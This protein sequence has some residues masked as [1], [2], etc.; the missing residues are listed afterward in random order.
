VP[1]ATGYWQLLYHFS[2]HELAERLLKTIRKQDSIR[3]GDRVAAAVSAGADSVALLCLLLELRSELGIVLSVA[4]VNHKLR[5]EESDEDERFVSKLARQHELELDVRDAPV[6]GRHI[7]E[8]R[9]GIEAAARELRHGFFRQLAREGRAT[10][11]ATAHTLDDQAE[12]VLLRIFRGTGIRGLSAVHPRIVFEEQGRAFGE[13][14]RPLLGF[15]RSALREFLRARGQ[16]WREDSSNRDI[17]F[18]RNRVRHRLLPMIGEEFGEAAIEH[19]AELAE[20]A[21]A[22]EEHWEHGHPE[23]AA[24][25][26]AAEAKQAAEKVGFV[27]GYRFSDTANS[28]KSVT[29]L[30]AAVRPETR[31][32][33]SL[34]LAPL[35]ALP[36][37][38]QRRLMR[39]WLKTN[40]PDLSISFR[41]IEEALELARRPADKR[42]AD[43]GPANKSPAGKRLELPGGRNLLRRNLRLE[44]QEL[45]LEFEPVG[46]HGEAAD[47]EYTLA[48]SGAVEVPELGVCIEAR[49]VDA[50]S[51]PEG[52]RGQLL[53]LGRM[54]KEVLIRNWRAGDRYWPAHTSAEKKVKKLLSDRHA[55]GAEKKLWPVAFA[56]GC[57]LVWMRGFPVPAA[58]RSPAGASQAIWIREIAG[59]M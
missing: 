56:E 7:S 36:L 55:T 19:M 25:A 4:H 40:A 21:R 28:S 54:P 22:E 24:A 11:I 47:Y 59:M 3:A 32:P 41:L 30:E 52:K 50:S 37:A 44:R 8:I 57:G 9:S 17:A 2:V 5:G 38:A 42:P 13:L 46:A 34:P 10:K 23:I 16:S 58:F 18:L 26:P 48:V 20:I 29:P 45:L 33:A 53:A 6:D 15:R 31:P 43:K 27:S 39:S 14:V 1:L 35:L 49:V 12:T 51:V